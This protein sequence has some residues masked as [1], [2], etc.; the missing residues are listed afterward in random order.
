MVRYAVATIA[1]MALQDRAIAL[2]ES[3]EKIPTTLNTV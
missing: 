1:A 2:K 3:S